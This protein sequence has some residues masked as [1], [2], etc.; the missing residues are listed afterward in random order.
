LVQG[1]QKVNAGDDIGRH[2]ESLNPSV[3]EI[4]I[5]RKSAKVRDLQN[6]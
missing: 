5:F 2:A 3:A 1:L 6:P 4:W